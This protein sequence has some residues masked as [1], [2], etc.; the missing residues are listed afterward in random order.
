M[1]AQRIIEFD[2]WRP[3]YGGAVVN[4]FIAGTTTKANL[5][6]DEALTT[7][8]ANPQVLEYMTANSLA[9]GKFTVPLYT[10]SAYYL[11]IN[12]TDQTGVQRPFLTNLVG[13]DASAATVRATGGSADFALNDFVARGVF[14]ADYGDFL[15]T[16][17]P[18]ASTATNTATLTSAIGV[19][20]ANGGGEVMLP[21]GTYAISQINLSAGVRLAR[22]RSG[23]TI[24]Q[25]QTAAHVATLSGDGAGLTRLTLDG[26]DLQVGSVGL[27][28]KAVDETVLEDVEIK[29]FETGAHFKGGRRAAWRNLRIDN[30]A[31][32]AKLYGDNDASGGANGDE[33]RHN[34]WTGGRVSNCTTTGLDLA[35]VD[36]R[37]WHNAIRDVGFEDNTGTALKIDGA[38]WTTLEGCWLSGNTTPLAVNDGADTDAAADNTVVGLFL[39]GGL[40]SGGAATLTGTCESVVFSGVQI[41]GVDF[42]LTLPGNPILLEDCT[43][44]S[45]VTISGD[46][47]KFTRIMRINEGAPSGL[48][49][50]ATATKAW[51]VELEPGQV[52]YLDAR[53]IGNQ[54]NGTGKAAYHRVAKVHRPGSTLGY[55]NQTANFTVGDVLTGSVSGATARIIADSDS[56]AAGTLTLRDIV[57]DFVNNETITDGAGGSATANGTLAAQN[58][59][60]LQADTLGADYE[61]VAG[62]GVVFAANGSEIEMQVTGAASTT[63]E[64]LVDV[65][66]T[67][68]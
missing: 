28:A 48:T 49:T 36:M 15:P 22:Q 67:L 11:D 21:D 9:Y 12:S 43:E 20:A 25:S 61:S 33:F 45:A 27:Y 62:W 17:N 31:T 53:V 1:G 10:A 4:V 32:G 39:N 63:I 42:T 65:K 3:G 23:V 68:S 8:A 54:R 24:L 38:R 35:Y 26:V 46:G 40:M 7:A 52:G 41:S 18:S 44:D 60:I 37:C 5:F 29:R 59:T 6:I 13:E 58:V 47:T 66:A 64:W 34:D 14:V 55:D 19:A 16:S 50:D 2:T 30:C 57:G 56:G 51:S